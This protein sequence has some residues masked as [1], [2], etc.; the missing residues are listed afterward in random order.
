MR[1]LLRPKQIKLQQKRK[2]KPASKKKQQHTQNIRLRCAQTVVTD[3]GWMT[4]ENIKFFIVFLFFSLLLLLLLLNFFLFVVVACFFC[5]VY[6][7]AMIVYE[8]RWRHCREKEMGNV[9]WG[10]CACLCVR[11]CENN[12]ICAYWMCFALGSFLFQ[13]FFCSF[14]VAFSLK[15]SFDC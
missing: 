9:C 7:Y 4:A 10:V 5:W 12:W 1:N 8:K 6:Y 2:K 14:T 13:F 15:Y 11:K 3:F